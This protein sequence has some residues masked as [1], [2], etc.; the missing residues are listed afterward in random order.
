M[1]EQLISMQNQVVQRLRSLKTAKG[2]EAERLILVEGMTMIEEAL[3]CNMP[4]REL[5]FEE[6][7]M[8]AIADTCQVYEVPRRI[9]EA[10]SDTVTPSG[11]CASFEMP[12]SLDL[13]NAQEPLIALDAV[14]DPGNAG[15]IWRTADAAG[16]SGLIFG[17]GSADPMS[18]KVVRGSMGSCFRLPAVKTTDFV[19]ELNELKLRGYS[20]VVTSLD[21]VDIYKRTPIGD[22]YVLVIGSEAHGV[23]DEVK[24]L[25]D[26]LYKL[27]MRGGAESL[28]AAVAAGIVMYEL[29]KED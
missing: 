29:T 15:T 13:E 5:V 25:A 18:P 24:D 14:S 22:K 2:R 8:P 12:E 28:N 16:F 11:V 23:C 20:I 3:S 1:I 26:V 27:P 19:H 21:G 17:N 6:G 10:I 7:K 9:L 4:M